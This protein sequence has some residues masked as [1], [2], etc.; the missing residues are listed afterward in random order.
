LLHENAQIY[1]ILIGSCKEHM[2]YHGLH[3]FE[4]IRILIFFAVRCYASM[5]YAVIMCLSVCLSVTSQSPTKMAKPR[6]TQTTSYNSPGSRVFRCQ[7]FRQNYSGISPSG[8]AK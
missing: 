7:N 1:S 2:Q 5:V 8:G 6:I 3:I 4:L